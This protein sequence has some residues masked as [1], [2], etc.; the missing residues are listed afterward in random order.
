MIDKNLSL[1][2][3]LVDL[4]CAQVSNK[5]IAVSFL[6]HNLLFLIDGQSHNV[7]IWTTH[8]IIC[9]IYAFYADIC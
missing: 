1:K 8:I 2:T 9:L 7:R 5:I 4:W 6:F 3:I